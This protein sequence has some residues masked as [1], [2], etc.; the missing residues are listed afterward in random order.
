[1][2]GAHAPR[3]LSRPARPAVDRLQTSSRSGPSA[4]DFVTDGAVI[5][6][7]NSALRGRG[8][9]EGRGGR[10]RRSQGAGRGRGDGRA[11]ERGRPQAAPSTGA[12]R[13]P[14]IDGPD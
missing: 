7:R 9:G 10:R 14:R 5:A 13:T 8:G 12:G 3:V 6:G 2:G 4:A 11:T 1:E